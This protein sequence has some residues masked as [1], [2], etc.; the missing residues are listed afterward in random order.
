MSEKDLSPQVSKGEPLRPPHRRRLAARLLFGSVVLLSGMVIGAGVTLL[1]VQQKALYIVHHPQD[2]PAAVAAR[3]RSKF[4]LS[5]DQEK[6]VEQVLR[7]RQASLQAIR[8]EVQPRVM[9]ELEKVREEVAQVL[10]PEQ[11]EKWNAY[12]RSM[13]E[14]WLPSLPPAR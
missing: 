14:K 3:L 6:R 7:K 4:R 8:R 2:A 10:T 11:A 1:W 13:Q 5:G 9:A 12:F